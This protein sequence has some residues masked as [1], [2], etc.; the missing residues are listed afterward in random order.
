MDLLGI[1]AGH[2]FFFLVEVFPDTYGR[3]LLKTPRILEDA[4]ES[5]VF[6]R[7]V[8][9]GGQPV[10]RPAVRGHNWGSGRT[11]GSG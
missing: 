6:S 3:V 2:I 5:Q 8:T 4:F 9:P 1:A 7:S 10:R 11:L